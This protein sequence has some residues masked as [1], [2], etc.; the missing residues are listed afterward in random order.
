M[1]HFQVVAKHLVESDFERTDAGVFHL[2]LLYFQQHI[3]AM[4]RNIAQL[5]ELLMD[6]FFDHLP[7]CNGEGRLLLQLLLNFLQQQLARVQHIA[8]AI[9]RC[10][11]RSQ[12]KL[13][14]RPHLKQCPFELKQLPGVYPT[15]GYL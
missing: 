11:P 9:E 8:Q 13:F 1:G 6:A 3:L 2:P 4:E 14:E 15:H 10:R 12:Q 7:L 5:V